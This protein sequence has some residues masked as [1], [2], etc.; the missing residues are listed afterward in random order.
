MF[1]KLALVVGGAASGKSRWAENLLLRTKLQLVYIATAE[2]RDEEM[3]RKISAHS[4]RRGA[5]WRTVEAPIDIGRAIAGS[6]Y[7]EAMLLD[8]AT[9]WLSNRMESE[10]DSEILIGDF[11]GAVSSAS[12]PIVVVSNEVGSG[13]VPANRLARK[14]LAAQGELNQAIAEKSD[15]VV[16]VQC[17]LPCVLKGALPS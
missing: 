6:S 9:M 7:G 10:S 12:C 1:P 15:L 8:C 17:G 14:F 5:R 2:A 13:V 3:Q 16:A 4:L 11:I